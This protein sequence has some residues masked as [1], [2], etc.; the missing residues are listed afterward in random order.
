MHV[1]KEKKKKEI[2]SLHHLLRLIRNLTVSHEDM[3][4]LHK[5]TQRKPE[6]NVTCDPLTS[7]LEN[8]II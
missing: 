1:K 2:M 8:M 6:T 3:S 4:A 7:D 5:D